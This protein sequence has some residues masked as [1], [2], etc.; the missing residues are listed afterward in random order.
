MIRDRLRITV[1]VAVFVL[2]SVMASADDKKSEMTIEL[3]GTNGK[4]ISLSISA[5]FVGKLAEELA[6][7]NMDCGGT[8][9]EDTRAMLEHLSQRGEGS[10]YTLQK[11]DGDVIRARR[12]KGQLYLL[13]E[14]PD[15]RDTEVSVPWTLAECM[16]GHAVP[17]LR[18]D[19]KLAFSI[20]QDRAIRIRIE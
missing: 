10:K 13:I 4:T 14:K 1:L 12:R 3:E 5:D 16:L 7:S 9:E 19:D 20:E 8:T 15:Q 11:D 18:G 2:A 17:A 6:S